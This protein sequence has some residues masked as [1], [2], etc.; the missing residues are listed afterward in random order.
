MATNAQLTKEEVLKIAQLAHIEVSDTEAEKLRNDLSAIL[1]FVQKLEE[2]PVENVEPM[3]HVGG[4]PSVLR[5]DEARV[6]DDDDKRRTH[7]MIEQFLARKDKFLRVPA[8][9][10]DKNFGSNA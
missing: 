2:L 8:I 6:V 5:E 9:F 1:T 4:I 3:S 10:Q 7:N